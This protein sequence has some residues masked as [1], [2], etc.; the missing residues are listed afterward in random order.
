MDDFDRRIG[1][2]EVLRGDGYSPAFDGLPGW[3]ADICAS[4][5]AAVF[6]GKDLE[7]CDEGHLICDTCLGDECPLYGDEDEDYDDEGYDDFDGS[8]TGNG[9]ED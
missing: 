7:E 2:R 6:V 4:C 8:N 3:D 9:P 5:G 1:V